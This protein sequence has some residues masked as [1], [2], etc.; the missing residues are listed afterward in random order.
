MKALA[1]VF[2]FALLTAVLSPPPV[3]ATT[4]FV[5]RSNSWNRGIDVP[6]P[7]YLQDIQPLMINTHTSAANQTVVFSIGCFA[8][9]GGISGSMAGPSDDGGSYYYGLL[10]RTHIQVGG[11]DCEMRADWAPSPKASDHVT[12]IGSLGGAARWYWIAGFVE[13]I[14][15]SKSAPDTNHSELGTGVNGYFTNTNDGE[16][17]TSFAWNTGG[18]GAGGPVYPTSNHVARG[19]NKSAALNLCNMGADSGGSYNG[20]Q[21]TLWQYNA[22][23]PG[24]VYAMQVGFAPPGPADLALVSATNAF[25]ILLFL[26]LLTVAVM[27]AYR[28]KQWRDD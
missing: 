18:C 6:Y 15:N 21:K 26:F 13:E 12:V 14:S 11:T 7:G 19:G 25:Y 10:V 2:A 28:V 23:S 5:T 20:T 16:F 17:V 22:N 3:A 4:N 9:A 27:L 8:D 1:V 24:T